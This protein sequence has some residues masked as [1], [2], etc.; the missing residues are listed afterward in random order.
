MVYNTNPSITNTIDEI[1]LIIPYHWLYHTID[2]KFYHWLYHAIK[3][4]YNTID[5]KY[6]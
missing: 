4:T 5:Y 6:Q 3:Y 1:P 2:Y